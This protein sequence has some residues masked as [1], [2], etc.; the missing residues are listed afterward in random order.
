MVNASAVAASA[1]LT[2]DL[3]TQRLLRRD[4]A[5]MMHLLG[6]RHLAQSVSWL[7]VLYIGGTWLM[8]WARRFSGE[9]LERYRWTDCG[10]QINGLYCTGDAARR[11]TADFL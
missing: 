6:P 2:L 1:F 9:A 3:P 5:S 7:R 4:H 11:G 10:V 8:K